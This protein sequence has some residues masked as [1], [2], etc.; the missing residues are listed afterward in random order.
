M[1][2]DATKPAVITSILTAA[3]WKE[4]VLY[5]GRNQ[6]CPFNPRLAAL[7]KERHVHGCPIRKETWCEILLSARFGASRCCLV[8]GSHEFGLL[9]N[10]QVWKEP[11]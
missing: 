9:A 4:S 10:A 7:V 1:F 2:S 8:H 11:M 3:S 5:C 6:M